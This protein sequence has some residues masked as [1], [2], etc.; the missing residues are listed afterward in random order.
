MARG[1]LYEEFGRKICPCQAEPLQ[2]SHTWLLSR[3]KRG[4]TACNT[5]QWMVSVQQAVTGLGMLNARHVQ[6]VIHMLDLHICMIRLHRE[7]QNHCSMNLA[8]LQ[9]SCLI[10]WLW[11]CNWAK[12]KY[13]CLGSGR[14]GKLKK[15]TIVYLDDIII[16]NSTWQEYLAHLHKVFKCLQGK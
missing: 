2:I 14:H 4:C 15:Y 6:P 3:V 13:T 9:L 1:V 16:F 7:F 11:Y 8:N 5:H 10:N 12:E